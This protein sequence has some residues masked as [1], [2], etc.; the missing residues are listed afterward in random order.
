MTASI[1]DTIAQCFAHDIIP[2]L[3]KA[4]RPCGNLGAG[5]MKKCCPRN[6]MPS[7]IFCALK[8]LCRLPLRIF[9][10]R[11]L[12]N[13]WARNVTR[14][15]APLY[16][17]FSVRRIPVKKYAQNLVKKRVRNPTQANRTSGAKCARNRLQ[18]ARPHARQPNRTE[19]RN[20]EAARPP[21]GR[22]PRAANRTWPSAPNAC[23]PRAAKLRSC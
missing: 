3:A 2:P 23:P 17:S 13:F 1:C 18:Q 16:K 19:P 9:R 7:K 10:S 4:A 20:R 6:P 11:L 15:P 8:P 22:F 14:N 21:S 5:M 12:P